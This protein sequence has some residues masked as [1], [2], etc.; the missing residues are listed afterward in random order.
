MAGFQDFVE[1]VK[2][3]DAA[4]KKKIALGTVAG[5]ILIVA[6]V[7]IF[8]AFF[9][10]SVEP[11]PTETEQAAS[12]LRDKLAAEESTQT[13]VDDPAPFVRSGQEAPQ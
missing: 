1:K 2:Y 9:G 4:L 12:E 13:E 6:A 7:L 8:R 5:V 3:A 10:T 11:V